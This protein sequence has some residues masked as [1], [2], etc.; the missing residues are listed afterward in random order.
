MNKFAQSV[1]LFKNA[2]KLY[3]QKEFDKAC[4]LINDYKESIQY[5]LFQH[6]DRRIENIVSLSIIIVSFGANEALLECIE[7]L[8]IL[9]DN[10][11]EIILVDNGS[12]GKS[13]L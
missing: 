10:D 8:K 4:S 11:F 5:D 9:N 7:S 13:L 12:N 3:S 2:Q 6:S 1:E